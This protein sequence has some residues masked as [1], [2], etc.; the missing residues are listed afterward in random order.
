[1]NMKKSGLHLVLFIITLIACIAIPGIAAYNFALTD[2]VGDDKG[3]G[4]YIYPNDPTFY[5]GAY[6]MAGFEV[7]ADSKNLIFKITMATDIV[8]G[9]GGPNGISAQLFQIY[10]DK[11]HQKNSGFTDCIPGANVVFDPASAWDFGII[12]EGGW[13][14][15]VENQVT[16]KVD[17]AMQKAL[18]VAHT[19]SVAGKVLTFTVPLS[20]VG[21]PKETWGYQV[22]CLGQEGNSDAAVVDGIKVRKVY[23][24]AT[25][26]QFGGGD[27]SGYAPD[28]IDM[29]V[30]PGQDQY[31]MLKSYSAADDTFATISCLYKK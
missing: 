3:P 14:N 9:W 20:V 16:A 31:T 19:G 15:E 26:W 8:N 27:E 6:D 17:K 4:T 7:T 11:D 10:I 29:F 1:M 18:Y 21:T 28:V 23:K 2:P 5:K 13:G 24:E 25:Q 22:L 12:I 30:A